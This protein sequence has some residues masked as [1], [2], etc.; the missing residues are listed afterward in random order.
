MVNI[1]LIEGTLETAGGYSINGKQYVGDEHEA[2]VD[3]AKQLAYS[4][5][6]KIEEILIQLAPVDL[7]LQKGDIVIFKEVKD[8]GDE[9]SKMIIV[10]DPDGGRVLVRHLVDMKIQPTSIYPTKDLQLYVAHEE[11]P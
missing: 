3:E 11:L 1:E 2:L 10:D 9:K 8:S 6:R 5:G 7:V 4:T